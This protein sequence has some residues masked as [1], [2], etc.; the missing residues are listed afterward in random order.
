MCIR[1]SP[2]RRAAT[3]SAWLAAYAAATSTTAAYSTILNAAT[4]GEP[5]K[6]AKS[7]VIAYRDV[8]TQLWLLDP[9]PGWTP[10]RSPF[11]RLQQ[12][13]KHHLA[14]PALAARLLGATSDS[15][16]SYTHLTL[17]TI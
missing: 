13:P 4:P 3:L 9:V 11:T 8:L 10:S 1:D 6:P 5:D 17:P 2:V 12:A 14:D 16:V 15:P 7:T